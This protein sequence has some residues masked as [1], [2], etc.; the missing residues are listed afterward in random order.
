MVGPFCIDEQVEG[1]TTQE[2]LDKLRDW[3]WTDA[4]HLVLGQH[5]S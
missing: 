3:M 2:V 1:I 4:D 5:K